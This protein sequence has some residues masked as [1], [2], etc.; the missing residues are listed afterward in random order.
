MPEN[1]YY[2][3][4]KV[5]SAAPGVNKWAWWGDVSSLTFSAETDTK[6]RH[7][8]S[9]SGRKATVRSFDIGV[10]A[11]LAMTIA[12]LDAAALA[13]FL[14]GTVTDIA[15][16]RVSADEEFP[17]GLVVG[18]IVK[19]AHPKVSALV[20][21]DS[22]GAPATLVAGTDYELTAGSG[23]VEI[24]SLGAY[25]QPFKADAY[26]YAG[27]KRVALLNAVPATLMMRYEGVNLA[28]G[29]APVIH[30]W[31]RVSTE[32][33]QDL[34]LITDGDDTAG[35]EVNAEVLMDTSKLASDPQGQFGR[36]LL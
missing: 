19:L 4:G 9:Y 25:V 16:G 32:L 11:S 5:F 34:A 7:K 2:G 29:N 23:S 15:G 28:E 13:R 30:E 8:E 35:I 21:V 36:I 27:Y 12:Q 3:Q 26:T 14:N 20:I 24:L 17:A 18:D 1:Y 31:Y 33:L 10:T 22:A 6:V